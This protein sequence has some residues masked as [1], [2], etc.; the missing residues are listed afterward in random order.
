MPDEL[1]RVRAGIPGGPAT[2]TTSLMCPENF[3]AEHLIR[4]CGQRLIP[5]NFGYRQNR[6]PKK[7]GN[8]EGRQAG[9]VEDFISDTL[10]L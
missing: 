6:R 7:L 9:N 8:D 5:V 3:W 2:W 10:G 4:S 1:L